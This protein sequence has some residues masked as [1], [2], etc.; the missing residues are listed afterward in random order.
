MKIPTKADRIEFWVYALA[1]S[2]FRY[3]RQALE[4]LLQ[5]KPKGKSEE[6]RELTITALVLYCQP[7]KQDS[8]GKLDKNIVPQEHE[9]THQELSEIR[10]KI[11]A[12]R[13]IGSP[14][15]PW[16][17]MNQIWID[18]REGAFQVRTSFPT[19]K[20]DHAKRLLELLNVLI[21]LVEAKTEQFLTKYVDPTLPD[22]RYMVSLRGDAKEWFVTYPRPAQ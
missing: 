9:A 14:M 2:S 13:E 12:H 10:D 15:K 20:D 21:P 19:I 22:N 8:P 3:A 1:G 11:I 6:R 16:G 18:V 5:T 7:F 4:K 17:F